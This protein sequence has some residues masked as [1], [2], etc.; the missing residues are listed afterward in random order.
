MLKIKQGI[1]NEVHL[2]D[3]WEA[4]GSSS[5]V[6][7]AAIK[8]DMTG[9]KFDVFNSG[10]Y[11]GMTAA[12]ALAVVSNLRMSLNGAVLESG[13]GGCFRSVENGFEQSCACAVQSLR[14]LIIAHCRGLR[15]EIFEGDVRLE[16]LL[17]FWQ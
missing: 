5:Q 3:E 7:A 12:L 16:E 6:H 1:V 2:N 11:L 10:E 14:G 15:I 4:V 17:W 13:L 9:M 8:C